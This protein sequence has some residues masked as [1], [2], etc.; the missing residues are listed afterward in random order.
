MGLVQRCPLRRR[1]GRNLRGRYG[2]GRQRSGTGA[3]RV[4]CSFNLP[5]TRG[6][7]RIRFTS[8]RTQSRPLPTGSIGRQHLRADG[9]GSAARR[10][11]PLPGAPRQDETVDERRYAAGARLPGLHRRQLRRRPAWP[12]PRPRLRQGQPLD[13]PLLQPRSLRQPGPAAEPLRVQKRR[14]RYRQREGG[15]ARA[16]AAQKLLPQRRL[17]GVRGGRTAVFEH[18]RQ[19]VEQGIRR[20][21]PAGRAARPRAVRQPE[22]Q[23]K[24]ERPAWKNSP[25]PRNPRRRLRDS[26]RE[27]LR[28]RHRRQAGDIRDGRAQ[29]LPHRHRPVDELPLLG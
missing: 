29:P 7:A 20:L 23:R 2:A 19:H 28:R 15:A 9:N 18:R 24:H 26:R 1:R 21:Q 22:I 17:G 6:R 3:R 27:P 8:S 10:Q 14:A 4:L 16:R 13:L 12:R 25:Y 5:R 11:R